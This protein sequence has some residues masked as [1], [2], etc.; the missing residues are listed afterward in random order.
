MYPNLLGQK[1]YRR[2]TDDDMAKIVG[3]SRNAY[4][5]KIKSGRFIPQECAKYCKYFDKPFEYL[6][7][8]DDE[9]PNNHSAT[10]QTEGR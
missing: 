2:L 10:S 3:L 4:A 6:F 1:A 5:A 8:T 7:A 9:L